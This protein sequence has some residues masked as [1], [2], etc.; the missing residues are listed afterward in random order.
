L[1][2]E[3]IAPPAPFGTHLLPA[4]Q[5]ALDAQSLSIVHIV[6]HLPSAVWQRYGVQDAVALLLHIPPMQSS[7][8]TSLLLSQLDGPHEVPSFAIVLHAPAPSQ[9]PSALQFP[10]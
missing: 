7:P 6:V 3:H 9:L 1:A 8:V 10:G 2:A 5:Y 4:P